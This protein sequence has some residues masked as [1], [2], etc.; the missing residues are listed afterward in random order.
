MSSDTDGLTAFSVFSA[1]ACIA[2]GS[3]TEVAV[4]AKRF[5]DSHPKAQ[6]LVLDDASG[7]PVALDLRGDL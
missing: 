2:Q 4:A 5:L 6:V 1:D 7:R 3:I